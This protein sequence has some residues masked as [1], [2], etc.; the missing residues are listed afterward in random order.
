M[1]L[2]EEEVSKMERTE[3]TRTNGA[4]KQQA[5]LGPTL[6]DSMPLRLLDDHLREIAIAI[7][8][9]REARRSLALL[10]ISQLRDGEGLT[11]SCRVDGAAEETREARNWFSGCI[12]TLCSDLAQFAMI[13]EEYLDAVLVLLAHRDT[14][15]LIVEWRQC[16]DLCG[17]L[18]NLVGPDAYLTV[19]SQTALPSDEQLRAILQHGVTLTALLEKE[20]REAGVPMKVN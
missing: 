9:Y 20:L 11:G 5:P 3:K 15:N 2:S 19:G 12:A 17:C 1:D 13:L 10:R 8:R 4:S 7:A 6:D 18:D 16:A 14:V